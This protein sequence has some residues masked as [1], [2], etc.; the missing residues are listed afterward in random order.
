MT[1]VANIAVALVALL[2][3][4][5]LVLEMFSLDEAFRSPNLWSDA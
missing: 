4:Y 5:F 3:A 2:H 1:T